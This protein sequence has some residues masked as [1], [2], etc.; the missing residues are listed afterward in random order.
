MRYLFLLASL[1]F[2]SVAYAEKPPPFSSEPS[3]IEVPGTRIEISNMPKVL[4]QLGFATCFAFASA[5]L[6]QKHICDQPDVKSKYPV[7]ASIGTEYEVSP[8]YLTAFSEKVREEIA[9]DSY[10]KGKIAL[11][12]GVGIHVLY[13]VDNQRGRLLSESC[14]PTVAYG[15]KYNIVLNMDISNFENL[16]YTELKA[17]YERRD[18]NANAAIEGLRAVYNK[19]KKTPNE[20]SACPEC[21]EKAAAAANM[22]LAE[23]VPRPRPLIMAG[24]RYALTQDTFEAFLWGAFFGHPSSCPVIRFPIKKVNVYP[25]KNELVTTNHASI[26]SKVKEVLS[27]GRPLMSEGVCAFGNPAGVDYCS[28]RHAL[29]ISGYQKACTSKNLKL[30]DKVVDKC[31]DMFKVQNSWG[32]LWQKRVNK[33]SPG[34]IFAVDFLENLDSSYSFTWIE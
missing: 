9:G 29:I 24:T 14:F 4:D 31:R 25:K 12:G 16:T 26:I 32:E 19:Y 13:S 5:T 27:T 2:A 7:C 22:E 21:L 6:L 17:M 28:D 23:L 1:F 18:I 34:W 3:F 30:G 15:K 8:I 20:A 33:N 10:R 11:H